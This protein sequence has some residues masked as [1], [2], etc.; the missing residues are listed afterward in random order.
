MSTLDD[1]LDAMN[2]PDPA[3][4][5]AAAP[6]KSALDEKINA[7]FAGAVVRK[8]LV[9][10]VRGNAVVPS[11]VLEYLLGQYATSDDESTIVAGID[12]VRKILAA[13]YVNRNE[14]MLA[15]AERA[16]T[17]SSTRSPSPSTRR[18]TSTRPLSRIFRSRE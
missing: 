2:A 18:T 15:K 16:A 12:A 10:A 6:V 13:H 5:S 9:K 17:A 14:H 8:D 7:Q 3:P 11:Y 1:A 4:Q